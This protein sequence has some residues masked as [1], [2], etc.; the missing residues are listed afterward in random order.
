MVVGLGLTVK[1]GEWLKDVLNAVNEYYDSVDGVSMRFNDLAD[2]GRSLM[3]TL[4]E[5][6]RDKG[7]LYEAIS[8][9]VDLLDE[10]SDDADDLKSALDGVED[11][12]KEL[13]P[14]S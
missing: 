6:G 4:E 8:N 12:V 1:I 5:E 9:I 3:E 13:T 11:E 14:D 10:V 2:D 7:R